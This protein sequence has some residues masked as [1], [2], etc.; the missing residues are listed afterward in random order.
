MASKSDRRWAARPWAPSASTGIRTYGRQSSAERRGS[1]ADLKLARSMLARTMPIDG[2][3]DLDRAESGQS[4]RRK[5]QGL[6]RVAQGLDGASGMGPR[7]VPWRP[8]GQAALAGASAA[9]PMAAVQ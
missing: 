6:P 9:V 5:R 3:A 2:V 1:N 8:R 4:R 7:R